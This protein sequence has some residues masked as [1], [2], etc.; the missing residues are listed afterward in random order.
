MERGG[1]PSQVSVSLSADAT[2]DDLRVT[3]YPIETITS[4]DDPELLIHIPSALAPSS[5]KRAPTRRLMTSA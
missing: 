3:S 4:P 2:F 1:A 5:T